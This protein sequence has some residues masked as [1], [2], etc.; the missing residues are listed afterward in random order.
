MPNRR[1]DGRKQ[2]IIDVSAWSGRP[3]TLDIK[4]LN[5]RDGTSWAK[6]SYSD[7]NS[8]GS[9]LGTSDEVDQ[10]IRCFHL[11]NGINIPEE[12]EFCGNVAVRVEM[13]DGLIGVCDQCSADRNS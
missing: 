13:F 12:C 5:Y 3:M 8:P 7:L 2:Y 4:R 9:A 10:F 1:A 6:W 11:N